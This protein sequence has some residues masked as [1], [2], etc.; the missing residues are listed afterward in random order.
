MDSLP[1]SI[2]FGW[3]NDQK[4]ERTIPVWNLNLRAD[5]HVQGLRVII[6][7]HSMFAGVYM[8]LGT[9][10]SYFVLDAKRFSVNPCAR[11]LRPTAGISTKSCRHVLNSSYVSRNAAGK[12][13]FQSITYKLH[14]YT[15]IALR[16]SL[17]YTFTPFLRHS[18]LLLIYIYTFATICTYQH[19]Y[20]WMYVRTKLNIMILFHFT[21]ILYNIHISIQ[22][23][24][25]WTDIFALVILCI[26]F[27][28]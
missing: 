22:N 8:C 5:E 4:I 21:K 25:Y 3:R 10:E 13:L 2:D 12:D 28:N 1:F 18:V 7:R 16:I 11:D 9:W 24:K 20:I 17:S 27:N 15:Y 26:S 6:Q 23:F 19:M 14:I